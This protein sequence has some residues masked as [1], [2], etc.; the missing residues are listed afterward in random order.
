MLPLL[1]LTLLAPPADKL[2]DALYARL[3]TAKAVAMAKHNSG[4]AVEDKARE[5]Q[6]IF[7][8]VRQAVKMQV[9]P[10][11]ALKVFAAQIEANKAVQRTFLAQWRGRPPFATA[12]DLAKDVRPV[13]DRLTPE[14][15]LGLRERR[16]RTPSE[17]TSVRVD[18][19]FRKGWR[20]ATAPVV[21]PRR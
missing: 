7:S 16:Y 14:I 17:I 12:P 1:A 10:E 20:V 6:V 19:L 15:L 11:V 3:L 13:L 4:A 5:R 2:M 9:D 21:E 18:P 8:A